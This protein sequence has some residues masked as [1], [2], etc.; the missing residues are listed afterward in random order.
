MKLNVKLN[1]DKVVNSPN[2]V[3]M[4]DEHD[5]NTIGFNVI[6]EYNLDKESRSQWEKRVEEAMMLALQVAE[7]KSFPWANASNIKFPL[8]TIA[9]L[10]FHSRAYPS[11][12]PSSSI[13]KIDCE[14]NDET[15]PE[16]QVQ[17]AQRD[18]RVEKHM[19]Y[20]ILKEDENW[21]AEMDKVLITVPIV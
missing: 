18:K 15:P 16:E 13:V 21:E 1:L 10:Q 9:A 20:Q 2:I 12:I 4:L 5:L 14:S 11:L 3:E 19:S 17:Y 7:A 8:V 6:T